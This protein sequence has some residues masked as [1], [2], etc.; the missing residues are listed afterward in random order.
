MALA[1]RVDILRRAQQRELVRM[2]LGQRLD[3]I[4]HLVGHLPRAVVLV[5]PG[6]G[7][8]RHEG[9]VQPA[10]ARLRVDR[11]SVV[12]GKSVSVRVDL[13]GRRII[14]KQKNE[15]GKERA[16]LNSKT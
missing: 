12:S 16:I 2:A 15:N 13:G 3:R 8:D 11:K 7:V 10:G 4:D 5:L 9:D 1:Q 14:K 6:R